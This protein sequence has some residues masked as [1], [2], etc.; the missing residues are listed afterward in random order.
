MPPEKP[1][2]ASPVLRFA[3]LSFCTVW[4][5]L[6]LSKTASV[7]PETPS[8]QP[9]SAKYSRMVWSLPEPVNIS[10]QNG[11]VLRATSASRPPNSDMLSCVIMAVWK[12]RAGLDAML[13]A[14]FMVVTND[15]N[16]RFIFAINRATG[17]MV[18]GFIA[19][20]AA[21]S[22]LSWT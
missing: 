12:S 13:N 5:S 6:L 4:V 7:L 11:F 3:C 21:N 2:H 1:S 18:S 22:V 16:F 15:V 8:P 10:F 14:G 19:S 9:P 17:P 20:S